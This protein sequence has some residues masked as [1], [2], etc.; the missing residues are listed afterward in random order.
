MDQCLERV[1][2]QEIGHGRVAYH[3]Q[4]KHE[5]QQQPAKTEG[6]AVFEQGER[7]DWKR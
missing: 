3:R 2:A 5:K 4:K 6:D 7:K 1:E